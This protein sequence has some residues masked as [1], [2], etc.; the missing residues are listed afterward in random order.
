M[1]VLWRGLEE[2][3]QPFTVGFSYN[4]PAGKGNRRPGG[5]RMPN[6]Q[7]R[8][9]RRSRQSASAFSIASDALAFGFLAQ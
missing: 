5:P 1:K 7:S 4:R 8:R 6:S 9:G 2:P 3:D